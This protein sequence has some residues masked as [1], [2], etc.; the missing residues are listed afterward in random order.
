MTLVSSKN[1]LEFEVTEEALQKL[2]NWYDEDTDGFISSKHIDIMQVVRH[3]SALRQL[4]DSRNEM[5]DYYTAEMLKQERK[6][7]QLQDDI[8]RMG[9]AMFAAGVPLPKVVQNHNGDL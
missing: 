8:K 6:I 3:V 9:R 5:E 2:I 1:G 4:V 7:E